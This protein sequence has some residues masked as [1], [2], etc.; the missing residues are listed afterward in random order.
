MNP[1][2]LNNKFESSKQL[3]DFVINEV[4]PQAGR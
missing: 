3:Y 1:K 2:I 4:L